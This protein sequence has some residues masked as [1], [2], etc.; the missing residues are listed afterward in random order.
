MAMKK[1]IFVAVLFL[2]CTFA[3]RAW[4][5]DGSGS[6]T[7]PYLINNFA[8]WQ[9]LADNVSGG[10]TYSGVVFR[11][12]VDIDAGGV[13]VGGADKP[14]CGT[15]DGDGHTLT[16]NRGKKDSESIKYV[17]DFCAPFVRLD[18][19]T[20]RHLTVT[21]SIYSS[22]M[23]AAGIASLIDGQTSTTI[24]DCHVSSLL[25]A[26]SVLTS[27]ASFV[28]IVGNVNP[29]CTAS[30]VIKDCTFTGSILGYATRSSGLVGY[31]NVAVSFVN[32]IFDPD[33]TP[34][35]D[36]CAT[37]VRMAQGVK[38]SFEECYYTKI[39][40]AAQGKCMFAE[41]LVP[42]G[43]TVKILSKPK[44]QYNGKN[45]YTSGAQ[46][47][48]TVPEGTP[49]DHWV[50]EGAPGCF[51]NDPGRRAASIRSPTCARSPSS[52]SPRRCPTP[53]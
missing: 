1:K 40:G 11:M 24:F 37:L 42:N 49:F 19:A 3:H 35:S 46:V 33:M 34:G 52:A 9:L 32:C 14:F 22:H 50:T 15:F 20:I 6:G 17:N 45:Y 2:M 53:L 47:L 43:C 30:P 48:L 16:Y 18:G 13:S 28:G 51:I 38:C 41:V 31:T 29:T 23:H 5:W 25:L 36:E 7:D 39:M 8:D 26:N 21:G 10:E 44:M 27:D 12:T 4:A